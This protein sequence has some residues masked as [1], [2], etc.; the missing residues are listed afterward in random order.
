MGRDTEKLLATWFL[1]LAI[2]GAL[3]APVAALAE[4]QAIAIVVDRDNPMSNIGVEALR[5]LFLGK[6]REWPDGTRAVPVNLEA[7]PPHH[8]FCSTVLRMSEADYERY[9]IDEKVR[10]AGTGPRPLS[11]SSLVI[12][13]VARVRGAVGYVPLGRIDGSVKVLSVAGISPGQPGY[14]LVG[15]LGWSWPE[16]GELVASY[17]AGVTRPAAIPG[18][19]AGRR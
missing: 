6:R 11:S 7:G 9:W 1:S 4:P 13:L 3:C 15:N 2:V 17:D 5:S 16:L 8:A 18:L 14:P 12:R 10:G 19:R